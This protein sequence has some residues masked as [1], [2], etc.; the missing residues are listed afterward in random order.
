M[1]I[2][3][4]EIDLMMKVFI[5]V[6]IVIAVALIAVNISLLDLKNP[7]AGDSAIGLIGIAASIC[8]V[9]ILVIF[10]ISK[11]IEEKSK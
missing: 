3:P 2:S 5:N 8:A 7:F 9:L 4:L 1:V 6:L 10:R 11:N